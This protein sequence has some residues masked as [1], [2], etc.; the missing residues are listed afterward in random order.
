MGIIGLDMSRANSKSVKPR[1][2][3][4]WVVTTLHFGNLPI[5]IRLSGLPGLVVVEYVPINAEVITA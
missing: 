3:G 4:G 2:S 5:Y 1:I